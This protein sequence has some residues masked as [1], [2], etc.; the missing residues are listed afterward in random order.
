M[1]FD[2]KILNGDLV[3]GTDGDLAQVSDTDKLV[4]D[5]LKMLMTEIG[6]N[7]AFPWYGS[8][9]S[10]TMIGSPYDEEFISSVATSQIRSSL[11]ILQ[12]LQSE[13]A[14]KQI[15][16]PGELLAA[17]KSVDIVRNDVDPTFFSVLLS[18][19]TKNLTIANTSFNVTL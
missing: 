10:A 9:V 18:V 13:Q 14:T 1:S 4:Q 12:N 15:V 7:P 8:S 5:V 11:E 2:F 6:S 3:V 16:T 19:L 17:I